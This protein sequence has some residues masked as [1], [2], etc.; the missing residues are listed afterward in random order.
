MAKLYE[1][2][3]ARWLEK[4]LPLGMN[5]QVQENARIGDDERIKVS[6]DMVLYDSLAGRAISVLDTKYKAHGTIANADFYQITA[7]ANIKD[8]QDAILVYP[9][10]LERDLSVTFGDITVRNLT[11]ALDGDLDANGDRFLA[12]LSPGRRPV[13]PEKPTLS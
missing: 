6:I 3:V 7:Y 10:P 4:H 13:T 8:C 9:V 5:L 12:G 1:R 2:F 11:F